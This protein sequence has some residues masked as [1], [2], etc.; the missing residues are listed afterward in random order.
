MLRFII[1]VVPSKL[2]VP[3][4]PLP[5]TFFSPPMVWNVV[6]SSNKGSHEYSSRK[7]RF[8]NTLIR[9]DARLIFSGI[10]GAPQRTSNWWRILALVLE[11]SELTGRV[12]ST[13]SPSLRWMETNEQRRR[14][15]H[16]LVVA[17]SL[18]C[19]HALPLSNLES[20]AKLPG[21]TAFF[22]DKDAVLCCHRSSKSG[23]DG[24]SVLFLR[25]ALL[26]GRWTTPFAAGGDGHFRL[27]CIGF[28]SH[29]S[30]PTYFRVPGC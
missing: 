30:A 23:A 12:F 19:R 10:L 28:V 17:M 16:E 27:I 15:F 14:Q 25:S 26:C 11:I 5:P 7:P 18:R 6:P 2:S 21:L 29:R 4:I 20:D 3:R 24:S 13:R 8:H 1:S 9:H 22:F